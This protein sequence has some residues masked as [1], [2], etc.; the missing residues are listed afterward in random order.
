MPRNTQAEAARKPGAERPELYLLSEAERRPGRTRQIRILDKTH[1]F[2]RK[3]DVP[4]GARPKV[5]KSC[6]LWFAAR[7]FEQVC[8]GCVP[9]KER[10]KRLG[11][12]AVTKQAKVLPGAAGQRP[13][14]RGVLGLFFR[15]GVSLSRQLAVEAAALERW[16]PPAKPRAAGFDVAHAPDCACDPCGSARPA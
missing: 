15:P 11:R 13:S 8:D 9:G 1:G 5:C 10:V 6:D 7:P 4:S 12:V 16:A 14:I 3:P 2:A